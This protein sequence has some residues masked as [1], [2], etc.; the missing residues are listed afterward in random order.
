MKE[1]VISS[2]SESSTSQS[3]GR[4]HYVSCPQR[5]RNSRILPGTSCA[6]DCMMVA[7]SAYLQPWIVYGSSS[8]SNARKCLRPK[9]NKEHSARWN[10]NL[11][12]IINTFILQSILDL[13]T[14]T[15]V[16]LVV[17]LISGLVAIVW[18][19]SWLI[20][21]ARLYIPVIIQVHWT[22][23]PSSFVH[24]CYLF[25]FKNLL[26]YCHLSSPGTRKFTP[27]RG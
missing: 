14:L 4:G 10:E 7:R 6:A 11:V 9:L 15:S 3:Q 26:L 5:R 19:F 8:H 16:I 1:E 17:V 2:T 12:E 20:V 25:N 23:C 22:C 27:L 21:Y 24:G 18:S 13:A